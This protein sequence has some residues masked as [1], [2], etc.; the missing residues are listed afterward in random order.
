[1]KVGYKIFMLD[2]LWSDIKEQAQ[3]MNACKRLLTITLVYKRI[4][5]IS[6][7]YVFSHQKKKNMIKILKFIYGMLILISLFFLARVVNSG[8]PFS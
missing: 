1:M 7:S 6:I 2:H 5:C 3:H 8:M 4:S